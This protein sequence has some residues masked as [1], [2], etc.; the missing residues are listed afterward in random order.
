VSR[1]A[2]GV[3]ARFYEAAAAEHAAAGVRAGLVDTDVRFAD[4]TL[5][6]TFA[7]RE[8]A[9]ALTPALAPRTV[10]P[11]PIPD[12]SIRLWQ[13]ADP[14]G[15]PQPRPWRDVDLGPRGLV[16]GHPSDGVV[17]VHEEGSGAVTVV[18]RQAQNL[19]YRV[20]SA[21][22]LPWWERAAPL[23]PAFFWALTGPGR[24][25]VHAGAVGDPERGGT[26]L[27]GAG[28]SGKTTLALAALVSGL[29]YVADDYLLLETDPSPVAWNVYSTAKLDEGHLVRFAEL[30]SGVRLSE[31]PEPQEKAVL[32]VG[33]LPSSLQAQPKRCLHWHRRPSFRCRSMA[34]PRWDHLHAWCGACRASHY[35]SAMTRGSWRSSLIVC[36]TL[37]QIE[38]AQE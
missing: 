20:P 15:G 8:L 34:A 13:E 33:A 36:S 16:L 27:A 10:P 9:D 12:G 3:L 5:R 32:D 26:L 6:L 37:R 24:H 22:Q 18:D 7:G 35:G 38:Q 25:L 21:K 17:V 19:L 28:G 30:R 14:A 31:S 1:L 11:S 29:R 4:R 23:R 2:E